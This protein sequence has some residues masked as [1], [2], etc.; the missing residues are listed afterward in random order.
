M[1]GATDG[2]GFVG[3]RIDDNGDNWSNE[4]GTATVIHF[5]C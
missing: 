2:R 1:N 3:V 4:V 5:N